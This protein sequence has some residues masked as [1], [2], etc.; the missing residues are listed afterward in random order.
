MTSDSVE[1]HA[2]RPERHAIIRTVE[3]LWIHTVIVHLFP[4]THLTWADSQATY[5]T[6][7]Y[8]AAYDV[9]FLHATMDGLGFESFQF[10]VSTARPTWLAGT[11]C[12]FNHA[13]VARCGVPNHTCLK[14]PLLFDGYLCGDAS[15][16]TAKSRTSWFCRPEDIHHYSQ[17]LS[18]LFKRVHVL[19]MHTRSI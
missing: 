8:L 10:S 13:R 12:K 3:L 7:L 16:S 6:R 19:W 4:S 11:S 18:D 1:E 9:E 2:G 14:Y 15:S 5:A 17:Q